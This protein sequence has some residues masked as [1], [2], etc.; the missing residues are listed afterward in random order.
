MPCSCQ[1]DRG[2][3]GVE[4]DR[5]TLR[6]PSIQLLKVA[7]FLCGFFEFFSSSTPEKE[8]PARADKERAA[9][10]AAAADKYAS[11]SERR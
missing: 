9:E 3:E 2:R 10:A 1:G 8:K 5:K 7:A 6:I 11:G 4:G